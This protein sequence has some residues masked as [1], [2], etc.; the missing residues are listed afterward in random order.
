MT[1]PA[2]P[3]CEAEDRDG[4][5]CH[6]VLNPDGRDCTVGHPQPAGLTVTEQTQTKQEGPPI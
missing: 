6:R 2:V 1:G 5:P 3:V 4:Q